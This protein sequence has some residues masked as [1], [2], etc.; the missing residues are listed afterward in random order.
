MIEYLDYCTTDRQRE[1]ITAIH[2]EGS[3][4]KAAKALG[5]AR[6]NIDT[7]VQDVK[8]RAAKRG[9]SPEHGINRPQPDGYALKG[10]SALVDERSGETV[11]QWYKTD[12]DR[13]R[14]VELMRDFVT[15]LIEN[16]PKAKPRK[17]TRKKYRSD[18]LPSIFIGDAHV[19][20]Y[21]YG[22]ETKHSD[23]DSEIAT[24]QLMEATDYLVDKMEPSKQGMLVDVGD[25]MHANTSHDETFNGTKLD[26]D[27][28]HYRVMR[29][30]AMVMRQM[31]SRMLD[32]VENLTVVV[33]RGN[34]NPDA[35]GAVQLML[36]FYY[37]NEPRV[38]VLP[39]EGFYHYVEYGKWLFGI[40]HGDKQKPEALAGS[41]ARDMAQAWGRTTHRMWCTGHFHK[42][43]VKTLPG[44]KHK[45][46][47]ALPPP[48]AWHAG[49]GFMGDGEM[50]MMTFRKEGGVH[51]S[52]V[53]NIPRPAI[54]ADVK[55]D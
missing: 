14:Q 30:S 26:V 23:F 48:D 8:A 20:M 28:R 53:Y 29:K 11:L 32:K 9:Y 41:M 19:G 16:V 33:A 54:E 12:R 44:C 22:P 34:H 2:K 46:F 25:F 45:V 24:R 15:G 51:S 36:E 18:L 27:T 50:E 52:H 47:G 21:A 55:I 37:E 3:N 7:L 4:R 49:Q 6:Q 10:S 31:I 17:A 42:E 5:I 43:S 39:T 38:R 35:A 40:H 1:I 13:E